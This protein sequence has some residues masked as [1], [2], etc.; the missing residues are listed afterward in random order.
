[1]GI[2]LFRLLVAYLKPVLPQLASESEDFLNIP[3]QVW[4][5][6]SEPL[7]NHAIKPFK[8]LIHNDR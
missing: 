8:A 5:G 1:M 7:L 2:N 3:E 4:P 6:A